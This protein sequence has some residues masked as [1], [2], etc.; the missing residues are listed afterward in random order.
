MT[1][2]FFIAYEIE[3][4]NDFYV[5]LQ[6]LLEIA[7]EKFQWERMVI[8]VKAEEAIQEFVEQE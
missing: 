5:A 2:R 8:A 6:M 3:T 1:G 7:Q 4:E